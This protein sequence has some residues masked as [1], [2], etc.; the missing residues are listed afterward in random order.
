MYDFTDQYL[1]SWSST[2]SPYQAFNNRLDRLSKGFKAV[3]AHSCDTCLPVECIMDVSLDDS[4]PITTCSGKR[5]GKVATEITNN[6][7]C[8]TKSLFYYGLILH[9]LDF[10]TPKKMSFPEKIGHTP[11]SENDLNVI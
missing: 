4:F 5:K 2:L 7:Y 6:G 10:S 9:A 8:S 11:A 3:A 1:R